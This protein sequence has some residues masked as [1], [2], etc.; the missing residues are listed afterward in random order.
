MI[1]RRGFLAGSLTLSA[2]GA[3]PAISL[4]QTQEP[5][6][7]D[8]AFTDAIGALETD[9]ARL[10][11]GLF[12][13]GTGRVVGRRLDEHFA[14]CSTFK[15]PLAAVCF[16]QAGK[17]LLDLE[18][19]L[20]YTSDDLVPYSP[21]TGERL[22]EEGLSSAAIS[23]RELAYIALTTSDN[24][25][26]NLVLKELGGPAAFTALLREMGDP[27]TRIDRTEPM[28]NFVLSADLRD[29][30]SPCA[31]ARFVAS[32]TMGDMLSDE[33]RETIVQWMVDTT[34]GGR[35][36]RAGL[37]D[38]WRAGDKTGTG[39]GRGTTNKYNDVAIIFPQTASGN[40]APIIL[41]VYYDSAQV[42]DRI[43]REGEAVLAKVGAL[44][45]QWANAQ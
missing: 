8:K 15:L 33:A 36:I 41:A 38:G 20:S 23:V 3:T 1:A 28:M 16:Y 4:G 31:M 24:T 22:K 19:R 29:T 6:A 27:T 10:G 42:S 11:V 25:A 12:D 37:P 32:I 44:A 39:L 18:K 40:R 43:E 7:A 35:R 13:T 9:P 30:T 26:A 21:V 5:S 45:A 14:M 2:A 17:G 34:T